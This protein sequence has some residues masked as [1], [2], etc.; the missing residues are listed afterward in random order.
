MDKNEIPAVQHELYDIILKRA[1]WRP[2]SNILLIPYI[3]HM[4][5]WNE[6]LRLLFPRSAP[7]LNMVRIGGA[8]DGGYV[9][10][11]P[12]RDGVALSLG[13]SLKSPW[14]LEMAERDYKVYQYDGTI[15]NHPDEH[16]NLLFTKANIGVGS[17]LPEGW[18]SISDVIA[19]RIPQGKEAI[20]QIDIEGHEWDVFEAMRV[21]DFKAFKQIIVEF[22]GVR[23][24]VAAFARYLS[25]MRKIDTTHAP[26]HLHFN[27]Y[28]GTYWFPD[29]TYGVTSLEVSYVRRDPG[30]DFSPSEHSF[31]C[32]LDEPCA[33]DMDDVPIGTWKSLRDRIDAIDSEIAERKRKEALAQKA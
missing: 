18:L 2:K 12:G 5:N 6:M 30:L 20:L 8:N 4:Q 26:V 13:V 25:V 9:M 21:E 23:P 29:H 3:R 7:G 19:Q 1:R 31:P 15:E 33:P 32:A 16:P 24:D 14:D 28:S 27:N 22:H 10:L 11:D 17:D